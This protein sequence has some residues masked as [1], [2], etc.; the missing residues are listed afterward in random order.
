MPEEQPV[1]TTESLSHEDYKTFRQTGK[2][3]PAAGADTDKPQEPSEGSETVTPPQPETAS[4]SETDEDKQERER[5]EQ[6]KFAKRGLDKRFGQLTAKIRALEA[7]LAAKADPGVASPKVAK[8][9]SEPKPEDF[10]EYADYVRALTKYTAIQTTR[11]ETATASQAQ[12]HRTSVDAW[13]AR[14]KAARAAHADYDA[15]IAASD[16]FEFPVEVRPAIGNALL[17][18]ELGPQI[19][20]YLAQNRAECERIARLDPIAAVR[21]IGKL[22]AKLSI[23][24]TPETKKPPKLSAAPDPIKPDTGGSHAPS[25]KRPEDMTHEEYKL[26]RKQPAHLRG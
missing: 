19:T 14:E 8:P 21:E 23:K 18:S 4:E 6:G 16:D 10:A 5:D 26:W 1:T 20:Y 24:P 9:E 11:E 2:L 7:Q 17:T 13:N 15:V 22:E 25:T 3:P 12:H